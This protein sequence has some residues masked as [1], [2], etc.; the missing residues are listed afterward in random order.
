MANSGRDDTIVVSHT[1]FHTS[2]KSTFGACTVGGY[3]GSCKGGVALRPALSPGLAPRGFVR[4][5]AD[6]PVSMTSSGS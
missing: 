2:V 5:E 6:V 4:P 1:A 3:A